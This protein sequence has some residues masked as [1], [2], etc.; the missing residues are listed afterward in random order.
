MLSEDCLVKLDLGRVEPGYDVDLMANSARTARKKEAS[1]H[2]SGYPLE[3]QRDVI[4]NRSDC[5]VGM[6]VRPTCPTMSLFLAV[7]PLELTRFY[8]TVFT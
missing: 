1:P 3:H 4:L 7:G 2:M 8:R 6:C 5:P